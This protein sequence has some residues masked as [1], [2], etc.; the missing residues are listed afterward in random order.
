MEALAFLLDALSH[1]A[2]YDSDEFSVVRAVSHDTIDGITSIVACRFVN[3]LS[4]TLLS[5]SERRR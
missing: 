2:N 5:R 1:F 4:R 3:L